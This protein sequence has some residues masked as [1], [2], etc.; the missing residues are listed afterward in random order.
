VV[1]SP[2]AA[3]H[4]GCRLRA[5][6]ILSIHKPPIVSLQ[7]KQLVPKADSDGIVA[8]TGDT[9]TSLTDSLCR[10]IL[11]INCSQLATNVWK[12]VVHNYSERQGTSKRDSLTYSQLAFFPHTIPEGRHYI[13]TRIIHISTAWSRDCNIFRIY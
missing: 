10:R 5:L 6:F 3:A 9:D 8:T 13:R 12:V 11:L 2:V 4:C 1:T 7:E